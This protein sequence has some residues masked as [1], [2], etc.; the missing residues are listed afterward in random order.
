MG[1]WAAWLTGRTCG[2]PVTAGFLTQA[3]V[4]VLQSYKVQ[5]RRPADLSGLARARYSAA[6]LF[7]CES[8]RQQLQHR[9]R[10]VAL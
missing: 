9:W 5:L 7:T 10:Q 1:C 2:T 8:W 4:P 3:G 6:T